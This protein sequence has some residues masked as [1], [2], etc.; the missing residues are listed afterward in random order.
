MKRMRAVVLWS[1][2]LFVA[3]EGAAQACSCGRSLLGTGR[4]YVGAGGLLP[5]GAPGFPWTGPEPL[6]DADARVT[7]MRVEGER[8]VPVKHT[9]RGTGGIQIIAPARSFKAGQVYEVTI[10]EGAGARESRLYIK[11]A[12]LPPAEATT[13]V[14][15]AS[16]PLRLTGAVLRAEPQKHAAV[17]VQ[18]PGTCSEGFGAARVPVRVELPPEV[19]PLRDYLVYWTRVDGQAWV[20]RASMCDEI[21]PGRS[22]AGEAGADLVFAACDRSEEARQA[23]E[24]LGGAH[25]YP[26][27]GTHTIEMVV[28]TVDRTQEITTPALAVEFTCPAPEVAP[29]E[30]AAGAP[31][32]SA[33][34]AEPR[35]PD[36]PP[37]LES[38]GCRVGDPGLAWVLG[39]ACL[40]WRRRSRAP[41]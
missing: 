20:P 16:A 7:V 28:A 36:E 10:R 3:A 22:W 30:P 23:S 1:A 24:R 27:P 32:P 38:R 39:V 15:I 37:A 12:N 14:T 40:G 18:A 31:T 6:A 8:R 21:D 33:A 25:E 2:V 34:P 9:I 5:P 19:E 17:S 29:A 13:R 41:R 11:S 26:K 4:L 35:A